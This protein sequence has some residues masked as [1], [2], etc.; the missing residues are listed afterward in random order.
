MPVS[1]VVVNAS[2]LICLYRAG[3]Q[4]L[5]PQLSE[6]VLVPDAV[7]EEIL[8]GPEND[9]A[10]RGLRHAPWIT[11]VSVPSIPTQ[12]LAW[13]LG[14]GESEVLA[15]AASVQDCHAVVDDAAARRCAKALGIPILRTGA[16]LVLA[17]QRGL[18]SSVS[19]AIGDLQRAGLWVSEP[20]ARLLRAQ[21][22]E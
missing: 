4:T 18:I 21:A 1:R 3:L 6:T 5:L 10:A 14:R 9:P 22:G 8:R 13:D 19:E 11:R 7:W 20:I 2:P 12:I 17:K 15:F 16:I